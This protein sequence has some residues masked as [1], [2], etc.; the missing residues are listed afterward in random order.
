MSGRVRAARAWVGAHAGGLAIAMLAVAWGLVMHQMGWGQTAHYAQVRALADGRADIDPWHWE[1]MDKA[2]IDGHFYSVKA[3]GLPL[4][5]LPAYLALDAVNAQAL[6]AD[7]SANARAAPRPKWTPR[8]EPP[9]RDHGYSRQRAVAV[10]RRVERE[11][12]MVWALT[13]LV[14]LAP[15]IVLLVCVRRMAERLVP[16]YGAA[17]AVTLG[18]GTVLMTF[19]SEF[20]SHAIA[21]ALAFGA[22][23]LLVRE[24]DG[25]PRTPQ[26]ALAGLLA[27]LAICFEYPVGLVGVV[28]FFYALSRD[29][30]R[31]GRALAY[32]G[33]ALAGVLP[34]FA[35]NQW[36]FGSPFTFAYGDAV[37]V[38]GLTGH[39]QLGLN[40][41]G[42]FGIGVP[43]PAAAVDL[44]LGGRGVLTLTPVLAMALAGAWMLRRSRHRAEANVVLAV[45]AVFFA[46]N[47]GYWLP[48]GGGSPGPRFLVPA[49][50]FVALG[51]AEAYRRL[52]AATLGL[53]IPSA[54]L[55]VVAS[56]TYP[57]LGDNGTWLWFDML[58]TQNIEHTLLSAA[59]VTSPWLAI[60]PVLVAVLAAALLAARAT[61][62]ERSDPLAPALGLVGAW[63]LVSAVG[64][65]IAGDRVTPLDGGGQALFLVAGAAAAATLALVAFGWRARRAQP[66]SPGAEPALA[67]RPSS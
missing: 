23:G 44:L 32:G 18:L 58:T 43:D 33:A 37:A 45:A 36:A 66:A 48:L 57:L 55:M 25:E 21:A 53:A 49:L 34:V 38:Q 20:F 24:R 9:Y 17:A 63:A 15:A 29:G 11:T 42:I 14:A 26:V 59:G 41:D 65:T 54:L 64:P 4:L 12:P 5:S 31:I 1:T 10:E 62:L 3:P 61:P 51:L 60:A 22:F 52:P 50:P 13:L 6:A 2:W 35:F 67:G 39:A 27:G 40:D 19:A 56:I 16:G 7:A 47:A 30:P 28:L 46:Y 8:A